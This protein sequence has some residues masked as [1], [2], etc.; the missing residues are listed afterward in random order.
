[1]SYLAIEPDKYGE[2]YNVYEF[3]EYPKS[4]VNYGMERKSFKDAFSSVEE[5]KAAYPGAEYSGY[6]HNVASDPGPNAP[7][8]F[9]PAAAGEY[10]DDDY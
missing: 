5:A 2:G 10:W 3:G 1:V 4:S 6:V 8:W 9:D 7:G